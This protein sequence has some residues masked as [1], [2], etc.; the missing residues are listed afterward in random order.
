MGQV[1]LRRFQLAGHRPF[2]LAGG[3]TGMVGDPGGRSEERNL[4]DRETLRHNVACIKG[5]LRADPR[6]RAGPDRGDA[7][8]QRRLDRADGRARVPPRRRQARHGQPDAGQGLG[9][10]RGSRARTASRS[11]SSA[12]CCCRPTTSAT[13]TS[14]TASRCRCGGSDQWGNITAGIDLIRRRLGA[15]AY[16]LTWPLLTRSDG[17]KMG[18]SVGG[19]VW[20]DPAQDVAVPVPPVLGAGPTTTMVAGY[21]LMLTCRSLDEIA[22][23]I[24]DHEAAPERRLAQRALARRGRPPRA[25]RARRRGRPRRPPRCCSAATRRRRRLTA[26][27]SCAAEVPRRRSSTGRRWPTRSRLL[28]A[29][30]LASSNGDARRT[31]AQR[32]YRANG[33]AARTRDD[34]AFRCGTA[35]RAV[36]FS[37]ARDGPATTSSKFLRRQVD[38]LR[39]SWIAFPPRSGEQ[40]CDAG[41]RH[42]RTG[43]EVSAASFGS[44]KT[45]E[46][47]ERQC[48]QST[49]LDRIRLHVNSV[50]ELSRFAWSTE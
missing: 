30:G 25:R 9:E 41:M 15:P 31:L 18:K 14:T 48:G 10:E 38:G 45:E 24:A 29:T 3:A 17:Q 11:P 19:A 47:T 27:T 5:Q 1:T 12:T 40:Q 46:K 6:L 34:R 42:Q 43:F 49:D 39:R 2:P 20:L 13:C 44:L 4:L 21:L 28:V 23:L 7:G 37:C 26:S 8:R 36:S 50:A 16:G 33:A 35:P 22:E 32:G